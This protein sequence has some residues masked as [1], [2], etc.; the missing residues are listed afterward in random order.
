MNYP[1]TSKRVG[2]TLIDYTLTFALTFL[3]I[4]NFGEENSPHNYTISGLPALVPVAFWF[5][6]FIITER[7]MG[8]TLGHQLCKLKVVSRDNHNLSLGQVT[9][10]RLCD[11]LEIAWCFGLIAWL[12]VRSTDNHQRLGDL[13]AKTMVIGR[14]DT[15]IAAEFD[16]EKS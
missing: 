11:A 15:Q 14:D 8:G 2:A 12:L 5:L 6:Y 4:M 16:F 3:Y 9:V 1:Y 10:R 13:V 7:Y